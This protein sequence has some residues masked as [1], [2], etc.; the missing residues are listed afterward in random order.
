MIWGEM[1]YYCT[2]CYSEFK[3]MASE[4]RCRCVAA[5]AKCPHC[6]SWYTA[7][8]HSELIDLY[9][10]VIWE[11]TEERR[12]HMKKILPTLEAF[13]DVLA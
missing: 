5:P 12:A 1:T 6:G 2:E 10:D 7:P 3:A 8:K 11:Q 13:G 4:W 9:N